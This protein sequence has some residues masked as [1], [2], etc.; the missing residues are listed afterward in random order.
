MRLIA[1][2]LVFGLLVLTPT[3][4]VQNAV[5]PGRPPASSARP[6]D[7]VD[8]Y[9]EGAWHL[10]LATGRAACHSGQMTSEL[11]TLTERDIEWI[12]R[13]MEAQ[14]A[15][16][17]NSRFAVVYPI[18]IAANGLDD[19]R[20]QLRGLRA[21]YEALAG[22]TGC[23]GGLPSIAT[24]LFAL[25]EA[26]AAA[27]CEIASWQGALPPSTTREI[28]GHLA[29]AREAATKIDNSR[30]RAAFIAN[31]EPLPARVATGTGE[32]LYHTLVKVSETIRAQLRERQ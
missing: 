19:L 10:A 23:G 3:W 27:L 6:G 25:G 13:G 18:V 29:A 26:T 11:R 20:I 31:L 22:S 16:Q 21:D 17:T 7:P 24:P 9:L 12:Q 8:A 2:Q 14:R 32:G 4:G 5:L 1:L 30:A 28:L 15:C